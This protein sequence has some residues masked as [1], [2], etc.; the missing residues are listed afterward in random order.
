MM[1][2]RTRLWLGRSATLGVA[3]LAGA[4]A[5]A[6]TRRPALPAPAANADA[7]A[8][9]D[10]RRAAAGRL[11]VVSRFR[12]RQ[13]VLIK[14]AIRAAESELTENCLDR[15]ATGRDMKP[16]QAF[17]S[18]SAGTR[19]RLAASESAI[20]D[21]LMAASQ[22]IYARRFTAAELD[23]IARFFRTTV[24][25]RYALTS[26]QLLNEIQSRKR[27]IVRRYLSAATAA[28]TKGSQR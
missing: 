17:V 19:A 16:C 24:G 14:D 4:T 2:R 11:L 22:T 10:E 7:A 20:L 26:P 5:H 18:P 12:A 27:E 13:A 23:E 8:D 28:D 25:Q 6:E 21:D 9:Y 15:A 1:R 3:L